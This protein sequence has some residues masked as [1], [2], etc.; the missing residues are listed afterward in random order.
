MLPLICFDETMIPN[1]TKWL[2]RELCSSYSLTQQGNIPHDPRK[3]NRLKCNKNDTVCMTYKLGGRKM[4]K[5]AG[6]LTNMHIANKNSQARGRGTEEQVSE[7]TNMHTENKNSL[8]GGKGTEEQVSELENW[9]IT[10]KDSLS[11]GDEEG[12]AGW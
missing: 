10:N 11:G 9:H 6:E 5:C 7:L 8:A 2:Q 12:R 3:Q 4:E 1:I